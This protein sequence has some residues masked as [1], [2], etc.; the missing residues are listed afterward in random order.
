MKW[1]KIAFNIQNSEAETK[2][3]VLIKLPHKSAYDGLKFWVSKKLVHEGRHS[4]E[5]FLSV[6]DD[7]QFNIFRNGNGRHNRFEKIESKTISAAELIEAFGGVVEDNSHCLSKIDEE[8]EV[9]IHHTPEPL[10]PVEDAEA[11]HDLM[12]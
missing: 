12:R 5:C 7:M 8:R 1:Q 3:G 2:R 4:Y 6:K 10:A 11:D 9:I